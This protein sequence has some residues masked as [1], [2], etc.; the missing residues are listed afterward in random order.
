MIKES[1]QKFCGGIG[2]FYQGT[3][4]AEENGEW[5]HI[6]EDGTPVLPERHEMAEYFQ[7]GLAW[8]KDKGKWIRINKKGEKVSL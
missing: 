5:F 2:V 7:N 3:A 6:F 8:V 1:T 4:V